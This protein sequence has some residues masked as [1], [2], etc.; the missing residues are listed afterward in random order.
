MTRKWEKPEKVKI[1]P[2]HIS[3]GMYLNL[4]DYARQEGITRLTA[5]NRMLRGELKTV[6]VG[7]KTILVRI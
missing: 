7:P 4:T 5:R 1:P 3:G 6:R 2:V